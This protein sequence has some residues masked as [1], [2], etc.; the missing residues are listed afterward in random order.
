MENDTLLDDELDRADEDDSMDC[1]ARDDLD[2]D[3]HNPFIF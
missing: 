1:D 2:F 3:E